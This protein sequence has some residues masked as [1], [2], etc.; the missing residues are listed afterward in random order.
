M[1]IKLLTP[2]QKK[3]ASIRRILWIIFAGVSIPTILLLVPANYLIGSNSAR[4][5]IGPDGVTQ[6][7]MMP[8][9]SAMPFLMVGFLGLV[10]VVIYQIIK[11]RMDKD[12]DLFL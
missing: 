3:L 8:F 5:V 4:Y 12:E 7:D 2:A 10:L 11:Y 1:T 6:L 9:L